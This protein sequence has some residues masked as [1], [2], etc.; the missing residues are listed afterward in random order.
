MNIR[1][2]YKQTS[3]K[4]IGHNLKAELLDTVLWAKRWEGGRDLAVKQRLDRQTDR[5]LKVIDTTEIIEHMQQ[6]RFISLLIL[7]CIFF[8]DLLTRMY[9]QYIVIVGIDSWHGDKSWL[10]Y[11]NIS[12]FSFHTLDLFTLYTIS[13]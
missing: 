10:S 5:L 9:R 2:L 6:Y 3:A 11:I 12:N 13:V 4:C 7:L 8:T 1:L